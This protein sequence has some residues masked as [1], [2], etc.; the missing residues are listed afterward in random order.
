MMG[1][2]SIVAGKVKN[3]SLLRSLYNCTIIPEPQSIYEGPYSMWR[4]C[5]GGR[6][7]N[8]TQFLRAQDPGAL[9]VRLVAGT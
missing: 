9:H 7:S 8:M 6:G 2:T 1:L 4:R 3:G 5:V